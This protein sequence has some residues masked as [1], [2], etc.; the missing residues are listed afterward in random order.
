[1]CL[2]ASAVARAD[3]DAVGRADRLF[4][5]GRH[6][7]EQHDYARACHLFED[8]FRLDPGVG[9]LIN[10][11]DCAEHLGDLEHAYGYYRT[12]YARMSE[13][14]DRAP[15]LRDRIDNI[16]QHAAK[17]AIHLEPGSPQGTVVT[18]DGAVVAMHEA[19]LHL[20]KGSHV[21][22]VTAVGYRG[23]RY[24]VD[25]GDGEIRLIHVT[26]GVPLEEELPTSLGPQPPPPR[27]SSTWTR[28]LGITTMGLGVAGMWIGSLAGLMAIDRR[29]VQRANCD[30]GNA[31]TP[32]GL[33]AA[34]DGSTWATVSTAT[35]I[36]GGA[37]LA[38]GAA[39]FVVSLTSHPKAITAAL[40]P[41][42]FVLRGSFE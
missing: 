22:L 38:L 40:G 25:L 42:S 10:L 28:P 20:A 31:C 19:P 11:G 23:M 18:V 13:S 1:M 4:K 12:A 9:T 14:D 30:A 2:F 6:A 21:V 37:L 27:A 7:A 32:A 24:N 36:A 34:R 16:E 29:D 3:G 41:G 39:F 15:H 17:L 8:S 33:D 5:E 26:P 35:F